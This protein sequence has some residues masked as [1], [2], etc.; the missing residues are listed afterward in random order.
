DEAVHSAGSM[1]YPVVLKAANREPGA[2]TV[3]TGFA[4]DLADEAQ[5]RAAWTRME[6]HLGEAMVPALVQPMVDPGVDVAITVS[7]HGQVG[8][9]LSLC[10]GGATMVFD[11]DDDVRVLPLGDVEVERF[12]S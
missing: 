2:K 7:E 12:V 3:A 9:V 11:P 10:P 4:L 5:L 6:E 8:P 1:G